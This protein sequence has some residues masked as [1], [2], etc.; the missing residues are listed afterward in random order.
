QATVGQQ[1]PTVLAR[2]VGLYNVNIRAQATVKVENPQD[3]CVLGLGRWPSSSSALTLSGSAS[4]TGTGCALMSD[5][6]V[7][8]A[9]TP[10]FSGSG[11][12][13]DAVQGC[14]NSGSCNPGVPYNY[15]SLPATNPLQ[16][17]DTE[18]FNTRTGN[19]NPCSG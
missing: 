7:K 19:T 2:L 16:V 8:Y 10:T 3:V 14:V 4:M 6:T 12:V 17:L 1:E 9:S 5:N 15:S 18:S 11:W 13:V